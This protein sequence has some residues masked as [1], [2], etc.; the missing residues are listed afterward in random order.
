MRTLNFNFV[1]E[2][3]IKRTYDFKI[4]GKVLLTFETIK[5]LSY[6][7]DNNDHLV[8]IDTSDNVRS[9]LLHVPQGNDNYDFLVTIKDS[10]I[11]II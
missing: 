6:K 10:E 8:M 11:E 5:P 2:S 3:K 7:V 4:D 9:Y 1:N